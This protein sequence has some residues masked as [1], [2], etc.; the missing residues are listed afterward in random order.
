MFGLALVRVFLAWQGEATKRVKHE[1][2]KE[3]FKKPPGWN[4]R[5]KRAK[6]KYNKMLSGQ[7]LTLALD[8]LWAFGELHLESTEIPT[9]S[10]AMLGGTFTSAPVCTGADDDTLLQDEAIA[11]FFQEIGIWMLFQK[12]GMRPHIGARN[13]DCQSSRV[14]ITRFSIL[15]RQPVAQWTVLHIRLLRQ[16]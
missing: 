7:S 13:T 6:H 11:R 2:N 1:F 3:S 14:G 16:R 4:L 5:G 8:A 15:R 9:R 10:F 12:L